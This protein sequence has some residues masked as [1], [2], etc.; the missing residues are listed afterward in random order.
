MKQK[1]P[2]FAE[3]SCRPGIPS[4]T[5]LKIYYTGWALSRVFW[6]ESELLWVGLSKGDSGGD[7]RIGLDGCQKPP[8]PD[9][10]SA[11]VLN[12]RLVRFF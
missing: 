10:L 6:S 9:Y 3:A 11:C 5:S 4:P 1:A 8:L 2:A 12:P 7:I